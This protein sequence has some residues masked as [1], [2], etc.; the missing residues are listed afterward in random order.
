VLTG[1]AAAKAAKARG[2]AMAV[3][4]ILIAI[5]GYLI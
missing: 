3:N 2:A 1:A 4:F 5:S